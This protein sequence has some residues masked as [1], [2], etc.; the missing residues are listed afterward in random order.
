M[1]RPTWCFAWLLLP[2]LAAGCISPTGK[3]LRLDTLSGNYSK[4]KL[5][6]RFDASRMS[7]PLELAHI[8]NQLVS[9]EVRATAP[10][11]NSSVGTLSIEYPH[12]DGRPG[13]ALAR[14]QLESRA[15]APLGNA[16]EAAGGPKKFPASWIPAAWIGG[17]DNKKNQTITEVWQYDLP[18]IELDRA[19][20]QLNEHG[21]FTVATA[22]DPGVEVQASLDGAIRNK[23]WKPVPQ[24]DAIMMA[25]RHQGELVS[26]ARP[27]EA[28]KNLRAPFSSVQAYR[29]MLARDQQHSA[30]TAPTGAMPPQF[31]GQQAWP[32]GQAGGPPTNPQLPSQAWGGQP[33]NSQPVNSQPANGQQFVGQAG[34]PPPYTPPSYGP[35]TYNPQAFGAQQPQTANAGVAPNGTLLR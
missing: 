23:A 29:D 8:Q 34:G 33:V 25:V 15:V 12:P 13:M 2:L 32:Q 27:S 18:K 5:V 30:P 31:A 17:T 7:E 20:G 3:K 24:L 22:K 6:Y 4:A 9:Y 16:K 28:A 1:N 10:V 19:F 26:Y 21:Y 14:V 35:R 11:P